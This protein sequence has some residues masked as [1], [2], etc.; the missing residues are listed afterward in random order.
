MRRTRWV[1]LL[2]L[3]ALLLLS[4]SSARVAHAQDYSFSLDREIVDLWI[5][6]DGYVRLEYWLTFTCDPTGHTIETVDLGLP[7]GDF[8]ISAIHAD[9]EGRPVDHVGSDFQGEGTG[10]AIWLGRGTIPPGESG[11][12]HV[13]VDWVGR[14]IYEAKDK[15]YASMEFSP[16]YFTSATV[17]GTSSL[18]VRFHLPPGVQPEEPRWHKSPSGWPQEQPET[19]LDSEGRPLYTWSNETAAPD[20][21]YVFGASFPRQYVPAE[22]IQK[23][24]S[25]LAGILRSLGS[26]LC[27]IIPAGFVLVL[28]IMGWRAQS[29]RHMAYLP[30]SMKVE[31]VGIKRGLTAVEAAILLETPLNR[32]LTMVLFS[33]L[34]KGALTVLSDDPLKLQLNPPLPTDLRVYETEFA[35]AVKPDG[36]LEETGL[37]KMMVG[38]VSEVNNKIKGFSRKES[39]AYY[40][41]IVQRAWQQVEGAE[42]PEVKGQYFSEGLEWTMLDGD[43][44]RRTERTFREGPVFVPIWWGHY[45]PWAPAMPAGGGHPRAA[46]VMPSGPVRLP[47]LPGGDFAAKIVRGIEG[48]AGKIVRSVTGFT[49]GVTNV[50]NPP[51]KPSSS[52][53]RSYTGGGGGH[54]CACACACA[55]CACACAGGGR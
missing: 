26:A 1:P 31:G 19:S 28:F 21:M 17:H 55:G 50:T 36:S 42:T 33:L 27:F 45:Q 9:V 40:R 2:I 25:A 16:A 12:V 11:T 24:P 7:P 29:R 52:G 30:P 37:Q 47:T 44:A 54:S 34:K 20:K 43:F 14:M 48:T 39:V 23:G 18:T 46:P 53:S 8:N 10:V 4:L 51:P 5:G 35:A 6:Q 13:V 41:D 3:A 22:V 32:V 15:N 49:G 38:L